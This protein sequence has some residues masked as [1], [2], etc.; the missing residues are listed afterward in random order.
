MT[1]SHA[2]REDG[3][4][5]DGQDHGHDHGHDHHHDHSHDSNPRRVLFAALL[6]GA[7][8]LVEVIGSFYSGSL[9][10]LAD[11]AHMLTDAGSLGLALVGYELAK[12][13]ADARRSFGWR[14][15]R[16]LIAFTNGILLIALAAWIVF[17]A[18]QRLMDPQPVLAGILLW[19]AVGGLIVNLASFFILHGGDR[20]DLNLKGAL[21]HVLGDLLGSVAAIA[22]AL[23]ILTTGWF[24]ADPLLSILVAGI[25]AYAGLKIT[26]ES[27]HIL[28]EGTPPGIDPGAIRAGLIAHVSG[29]AEIHHI[30]AWTLSERDHV[31]TLEVIAAPGEDAETLRRAVK[32]HLAE[33]FHLH[34]AT[35]EVVAA[36]A[37]KSVNATC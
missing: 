22:A 10:L 37:P 5:T 18:L 24:A 2:H 11:A 33:R 25:T 8:M 3:S 35:V 1:H 30:H 17:E 26:R 15:M 34:H 7:F 32:S 20:E 27:A 29:V 13:P 9:A 19:I 28:L 16:I 21:G 23:I 31:I 14:R 4:C 6:T 36:G 12:R